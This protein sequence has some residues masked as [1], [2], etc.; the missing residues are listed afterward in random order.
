MEEFTNKEIVLKVKLVR[1]RKRDRGLSCCKA[2]ND[3]D[4]DR[5]GKLSFS[6]FK[7]WIERNPEVRNF[8]DSVFPIYDET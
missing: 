8:F 6:Q 4:L 5:N 3:C 2:F 1:A 7:M